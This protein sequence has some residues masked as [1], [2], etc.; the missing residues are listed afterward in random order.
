MTVSALEAASALGVDRGTILSWLRQ[1]APVVRR[2]IG[3]DAHE[4]DLGALVE[5]RIE[6][7]VERERERGEKRIEV[8]RAEYEQRRTMPPS[9]RQ[10]QARKAFA[11]LMPFGGEG[12]M[13]TV[14]GPEFA[15]SL[16]LWDDVLELLGWGLPFVSAGAADDPGAWRFSTAHTARWLALVVSDLADLGIADSVDTLAA[17]LRKL[18]GDEPLRVPTDGYGGP[19]A[20]RRRSKAGR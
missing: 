4:I 6:R 16:F 20:P 15:G 9:E 7:A 19:R 3:G 11:Q 13:M 18:R 1:G 12:P 5:W 2:A 14:S 17:A 8:M 10:E